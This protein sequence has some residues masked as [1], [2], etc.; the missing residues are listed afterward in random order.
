[1]L[2]LGIPWQDKGLHRIFTRFLGA[3]WGWGVIRW[4]P[5][6]PATVD[7]VNPKDLAIGIPLHVHED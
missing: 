6:T 2:V 3:F 5:L 1:M 7:L 4:S